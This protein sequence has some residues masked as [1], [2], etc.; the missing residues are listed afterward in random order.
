MGWVLTAFSHGT[1]LAT[2]AGRE[3]LR[4]R[5]QVLPPGETVCLV[6]P[7]NAASL[8]V[9]AKPGFHATDRTTHHAAAAVIL[10]RYG[11]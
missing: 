2:E 6:D 8:R 10:R 4:W 1:G 7:D 11:Q 5:D 9:A 3:A